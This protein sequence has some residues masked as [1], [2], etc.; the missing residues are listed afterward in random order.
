MTEGRKE[1]N[2]RLTQVLCFFVGIIKNNSMFSVYYG[3]RHLKVWN[4]FNLAFYKFQDV[5]IFFVILF[6]NTISSKADS[7]T[8]LFQLITLL[9]SFFGFFSP[10]VVICCGRS[11]LQDSNALILLS[12]LLSI[13][14]SII[15]ASL[16]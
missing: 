16:I 14:L 8:A 2:N 7:A 9:L 3:F 1:H 11:F 15:F 13:S 4:F 5:F 10:S 6:R 12:T